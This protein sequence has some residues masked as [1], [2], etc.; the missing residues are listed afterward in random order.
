MPRVYFSDKEA[1]TVIAIV[2]AFLINHPQS[3]QADIV[4]LVPNRIKV[5]IE[6]QGKKK[7]ITRKGND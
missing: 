3:C 2:E 5:C 4:K 7:V 6:K 1:A